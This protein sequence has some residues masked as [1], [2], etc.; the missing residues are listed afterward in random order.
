MDSPVFAVVS[1]IRI[2]VLDNLSIN[3]F[4]GSHVLIPSYLPYGYHE[5]CWNTQCTIEY[6]YNIRRTH[7]TRCKI[8]FEVYMN[9]YVLLNERFI[10]SLMFLI[11]Y[12]APFIYICTLFKYYSERFCG[13][14]L[15][16]FVTIFPFIYYFCSEPKP[17]LKLTPI[18][19]TQLQV[20]NDVF[21]SSQVNYVYSSSCF[22][23]I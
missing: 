7:N 16:L 10:I 13:S 8:Y 1:R 19:R 14:K 4:Y 22:L 11:T 6:I 2:V 9:T 15:C 23:I 12:C 20:R 21:L 5:S 18:N 17:N 3:F